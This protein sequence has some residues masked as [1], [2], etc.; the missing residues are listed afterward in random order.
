MQVGRILDALGADAA[1][2]LIIV[3]SDHGEAFGEHG[4]ITHTL[5]VY[6]TTLRVPLIMNGAG[7]L[8]NVIN[9]PISL[10]DVVPTVLP[11]LGLKGP[12]GDGI[13]FGPALRGAAISDRELYAE[14][15]APL[16]DFGWSPL[17]TIRSGGFK[18]IEAP[19]AELYELSKDPGE[20]L[21]LAA[22][23]GPRVAEL[24][25]RVQRYRHRRSTRRPTDPE[26]LG[27]L[28][29]LGYLSGRGS[30]H[31]R[32]PPRPKG[33][34]GCRGEDGTCRVGRAHGPVLQD[35]LEQILREDPRNPQA[36]LRMGYLLIES[37]NC[38]GARPYLTAAI[39]GH[40]P[41]VEAHLGLALCPPPHVGS[42]RPR[43]R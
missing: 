23:Q 41:G 16:F 15:F 5:F 18:F 4:E 36:N 35:A 13:D 30:D 2:S 37:K 43:R 33:S 25:D 14:S 21:N 17:R 34:P 22:E 9:P 24:R 26:A 38:S 42:A 19:R 27:R 3:A 20:T 31:G 32:R 29:A 1:A 10:V 28:Q 6:D 8:P 7:I 40:V 11:L 12:S 39:A